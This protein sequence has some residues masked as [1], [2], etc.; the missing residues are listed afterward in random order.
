[1]RAGW[2]SKINQL[3]IG[4]A[5]SDNFN[6]KVLNPDGA[7]IDWHLGALKHNHDF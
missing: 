4:E 2:G 1:M 6:G 3:S 7:T 5:L